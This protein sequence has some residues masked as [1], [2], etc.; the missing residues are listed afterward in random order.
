MEHYAVIQNIN[1]S[2][3]VKYEGENPAALEVNYYS[4]VA[5]LLNDAGAVKGVVKLVDGNLDVYDGCVK[6]ID[7]PA[8]EG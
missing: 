4:L 1:G 5:A 7:K 8:K 3:V 6:F 2:C